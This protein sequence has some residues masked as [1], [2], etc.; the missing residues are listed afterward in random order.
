MGRPTD[1]LYLVAETKSD[2]T[3]LR[4]DET[5]KNI[6]GARHFNDALHVPYKVITSASELP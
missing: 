2:T 1:T 6:C 3:T 5:R 4:P